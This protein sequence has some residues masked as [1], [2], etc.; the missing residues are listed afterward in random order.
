MLPGAAHDFPDSSTGA[1]PRRR[2][3][4]GLNACAP[5][6]ITQQ[7]LPHWVQEGVTYFVTF[8]LAD[9]VPV[10]LQ[11]Q[12]Q[13]EREAWLRFHPEPWTTEVEDEYRRLFPER[14]DQWLDAGMGECHL[15][16]AELRDA[17]ERHVRH[18]DGERYDVDAFVLMPN[19]VHLLVTPRAGQAL[20]EL[21]KA[22]K[23]TSART[24]NKLLG[25]TGNSFW[26]E[27]SYNRIVRDSEELTAFRR[28]IEANPVRAGLR[29]GEFT[30]SMQNVLYVE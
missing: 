19:H 18:F 11:Q 9:A 28:Y 14:M 6:H 24:C 5:I 3:F 23:G 10:Q 1:P 22:I 30:L 26:M 25:R 16:C 17:V 4:R 20:F 12:W 13:Q 21:L 7:R 8:R 27:D 2:R 29:P 15:R